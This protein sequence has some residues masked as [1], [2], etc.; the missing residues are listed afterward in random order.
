MTER[1]I[2]WFYASQYGKILE[3][4]D[5]ILVFCFVISFSIATVCQSFLISTFFTRANLAAACGGFIFFICFLPYNVLDMAEKSYSFAT[6]ILLVTG[7]FLN[8]RSTVN[9]FLSA[10]SEFNIECS[11]RNRLLVLCQTGTRSFGSKL[12][13][14]E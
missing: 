7:L 8:L 14:F 11:L 12:V 3:K 6:K 1:A 9:E 13:Q 10:V 5:P 4:S 2:K